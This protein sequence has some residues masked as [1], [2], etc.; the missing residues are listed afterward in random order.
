M[1]SG[2]H[3]PDSMSYYDQILY[4]GEHCYPLEL[5]FLITE[6][7]IVEC[8]LSR[9]EFEYFYIKTV[10]LSSRPQMKGFVI[11]C[12]WLGGKIELWENLSDS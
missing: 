3:Y 2:I 8:L 7:S 1:F 4:A 10:F 6:S 5:Y 11:V 9:N 12:S